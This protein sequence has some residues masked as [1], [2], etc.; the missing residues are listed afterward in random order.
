MD[1]LKK[2]GHDSGVTEDEANTREGIAEVED[3]YIAKMTSMWP[4][5]KKKS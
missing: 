2:H 3:Q 4:T 1:Q 5:R